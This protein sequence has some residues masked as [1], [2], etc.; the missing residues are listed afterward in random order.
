[1]KIGRNDNSHTWAEKARAYEEYSYASKIAKKSIKA[2]KRNCVN[3]LATETEEADHPENVWELYTTIKKL[4][5][6]FGKPGRLVKDTGGKVFWWRRSKEEVGG[7]PWR[8]TKQT[9]STGPA[10]DDL[11]LDSDPPFKEEIAKPS[12]SWEEICQVIK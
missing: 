7:A 1:M 5:G 4:S 8:A 3:M 10:S 9:S 12:N 2:D 11:P 6:K